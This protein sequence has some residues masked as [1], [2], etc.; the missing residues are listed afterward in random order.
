MKVIGLCGGSGSGK[1][2]VCSLF[3]EL[4]V[5]SIDTDKLYHDMISTDTECT[6]ELLAAFG[7]QVHAHPGIDR[8]ALREIVFASSVNLNRLNEITHRHI[9][10]SVRNIIEH[11]EADG[12]IIDAPLLF[13]SGFDK[14]CDLTVCVV[15]DND[16]RLKRILER[17]GI[18][19]D[20]AQKRIASQIG[21]AELI[22]RCD[23]AL[24]NN[25]GTDELKKKVRELNKTL[26]NN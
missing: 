19:R 16:I 1:S 18:S 8:A 10:N 14:E 25:S 9:L 23:Y 6:R 11:T 2:T 26:F 20:A 17:D 22:E 7:E 3:A 12:I 4:G 5:P 21:N 15:A 13:E 24:E